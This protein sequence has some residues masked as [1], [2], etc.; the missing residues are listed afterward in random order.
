MKNESNISLIAKI[1]LANE[2]L[3]VKNLIGTALATQKSKLEMYAT[4]FT[5]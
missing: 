3:P 4:G 1:N 2:W 5:F